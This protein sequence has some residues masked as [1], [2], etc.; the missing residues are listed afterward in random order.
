MKIAVSD[1]AFTGFKAK[2]LEKLPNKYGIEF[3][4]EFGKNSYWDNILEQIGKNR[5][6]QFSMHAPCVSINL[7]NTEDTEYL[8]IFRKAIVYAQRCKAE[9][10]VIHTN[11]QWSGEKSAVQ[12]LVL[13]KIKKIIEMAADYQVRILIENVGL[14]TKGTLLFD[15]GEYQKLLKKLPKARALLDVGHAHINGWNI[16]ECIKTLDSRL[17]AIHLHDNDGKKDQHLAIGE[18]NIGWDKVFAAIKGLG[19]DTRLILEYANIDMSRLLDN[20]KLIEKEFLA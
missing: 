1:L 7:A 14:K 20:I 10:L 15:W 5:S 3:F 11:E 16:S 9:F 4:Y 17:W 6:I 2:E 13:G 19:P 12:E 18:G 8:G